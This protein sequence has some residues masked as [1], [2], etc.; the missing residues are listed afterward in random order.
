MSVILYFNMTPT[1]KNTFYKKLHT[2]MLHSK[3]GLVKVE[4]I[5]LKELFFVHKFPH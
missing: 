2:H 4:N 5:Y 3:M 1:Y